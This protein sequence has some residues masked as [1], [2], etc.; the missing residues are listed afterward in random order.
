MDV[1]GTCRPGIWIKSEFPFRFSTQRSWAEILARWT[2]KRS[3]RV[4]MGEVRIIGE[5]CGVVIPA[6][7]NGKG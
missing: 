4:C 3:N 5:H 1:I 6:G 2:S 7:L